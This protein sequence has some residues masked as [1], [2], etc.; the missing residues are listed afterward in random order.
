MQYYRVF[1]ADCKMDY[2]QGGYKPVICGACGSDFIAVKAVGA[3]D[4]TAVDDMEDFSGGL[5]SDA[6]TATGMYD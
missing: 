2:D 4:S 5:P 1:C 6:A 3:D